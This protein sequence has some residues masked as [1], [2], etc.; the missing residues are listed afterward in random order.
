[1]SRKRLHRYVNEFAGRYNSG[2]KSLL[3]R[4]AELVSGMVG[5]GLT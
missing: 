2:G 1:M 5:E 4:M 3:D